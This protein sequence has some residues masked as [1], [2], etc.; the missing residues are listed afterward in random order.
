MGGSAGQ[1]YPVVLMVPQGSREI[2][3]ATVHCGFGDRRLL[4]VAGGC[5]GALALGRYHLRL[6]NTY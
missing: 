3:P 4:C 6:T 2:C 1:R 5:F